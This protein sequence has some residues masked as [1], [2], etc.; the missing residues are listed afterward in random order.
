MG[1]PNLFLLRFLFAGTDRFYI[2]V[3]ENP[4]AV[5]ASSLR[6]GY[7]KNEQP[8]GYSLG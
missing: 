8:F 2:L 3:Y 4:P 1:L 5:A 6:R 7:K